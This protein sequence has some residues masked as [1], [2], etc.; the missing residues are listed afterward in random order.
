LLVS[1][2]VSWTVFS[3]E[4][5]NFGGDIFPILAS[6]CIKCHGEAKQEGELR[7]DSPEGIREGGEFGSV[8]EPGDAADSALID[9][10]TRAHDDK[11]RMPKKADPLSADVIE[12]V[13]AWIEQGAPYTGWDVA[14]TVAANEAVAN[15]LPDG[16][17]HWAFKAPTRPEAPT[18]R[19]KAWPRN[20]IDR[21]V[22]AALDA[23]DLA[24][25][26]DADRVTL[27]RRLSLDVTGLP[28]TRE[29]MDEVLGDESP[30]WYEHLIDRLLASPHYG[31]RWAR[32]WLDNAQFA[33]S[34]GFEKDKPRRVTAWRDWV[35]DALNADMPYDDFIVEQVA[36]DLLPNATQSQRI[37]T[38]FL[39]NNML[40]EEGG[41]DPEQFRMEGLFN[42]MDVL[43]RSVLGLTVNC[44]QCHTHKYDPIS[45]T[46]YYRMMA[47]LN[48]TEDLTMSVFTPGEQVL[49][50]DI[51]FEV[52]ALEAKLKR[53]N[54]G[55]KKRMLAWMTEVRGRADVEWHALELE[56]DDTSA[57]GQKTVAPGDGS[58]IFQSYAPARHSPKMTARSPLSRI[59]AVRLE[60]MTDPVL[61]RKGPGRSTYGVAALSEFELRTA[62]DGTEIKTFDDWTPV[63]FES[64]VADV[65][66][67]T[68][69]LS[70]EYPGSRNAAEE[71]RTV[72]PAAFAIDGDRDT[73]WTTDID[74]GRRNQSRYA[75]FTLS[76]PLEV[77]AD[78]QLAIRLVQ[79]HGGYKP[80]ANQNNNVGRF[81]ISVTGDGDVPGDAIPEN[82]LV[83]IEMPADSRTTGD[84]DL[85]F[86]YWRELQPEYAEV[87]LEI[88]GLWAAHPV[89]DTQLV[90]F[91]RSMPR[92][93]R[94]LE[95]GDFLNPAEVVTPGTPEFLH[96]LEQSDEPERLA[97]ARWL[98]DEKSP[99]TARAFVNRV[100]QHYFG[101]G[102]VATSS[103][104]GLQGD[105]PSHPEL[106]DWL[107][108][109]FMESGWSVKELHRLILNSATYRQVS[110]VSEGLYRRDS[111]NR[112]L[113][114]GARFRVDGEV[115]RDIA[116][117]ASGLLNT[118]VGG[119]SVHPPAPLYL[120]KPPASFSAKDW[121]ID[122]DDA[123]YRRGLYTFRFRSVP[124]PML[125]VFDTPAGNAPCT[126][127]DVSNS[128]LQA[129][130]TLNED[131]FFECA[132]ALGELI[133]REGGLTDEARVRYAFERCVTRSPSK[134]EMRTLTKYLDRQRERIGKGELDSAAITAVLPGSPIM[135]TDEY[136]AWILLSRVLLNL[137]ETIVRQ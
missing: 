88:D 135:D 73:A 131:L 59:T 34:D 80:P 10:L 17:D 103:D 29:L 97:F 129:L 44:A 28:P 84:L 36:G 37:A 75:A 50:T 91:E 104:L 9:L 122:T 137:D 20:S 113:A 30:Q 87:N 134:F 101:V 52:N 40:N 78:A 32:H 123:R 92:V 53:D 7:L 128:P 90:M 118:R 38:G 112:L 11:E 25:S 114:R 68:R 42:R 31:E 119:E 100:W 116:L 93:T 23:E 76:E 8:I 121:D 21:F 117:A 62:P 4:S 1:L 54:R 72:G 49:R 81:R 124:Y 35:I 69:T 64:V 22:A 56:F 66:P 109:E 115:V 27:L 79:M 89:G 45:H 13:S 127:R 82:V 71:T 3:A 74:P 60:L 15:E 95:R 108:V 83:A 33:D 107:S 39:R 99:T 43:G 14:M 120:Y 51:E 26:P 24:P 111:D 94:R 98:A 130:T 105:A 18:V 57:G 12:M 132:S 136:A 46:D 48:T 58:Y 2:S 16:K 133:I 41:A 63:A 102:L 67:V 96:P 19:D 5:V 55:W 125:Q 65:N 110:G 61:P 70:G 47:F 85:V 6:H 77:D 86:S 106:L 126:R